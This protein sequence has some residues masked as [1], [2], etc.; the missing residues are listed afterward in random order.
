VPESPEKQTLDSEPEWEEAP[1]EAG[2]RT[3]ED[4]DYSSYSTVQPHLITEAEMKDTVRDLDLPK[5]KAQ[6]LGSRL[7]P[8]ESVTV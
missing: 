1:T 2:K 4:Q 7:Q 8:C 5:T 3:R 6:Q